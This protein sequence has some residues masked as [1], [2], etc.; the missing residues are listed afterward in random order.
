M[1][2]IR[3]FR[4]RVLILNLELAAREAIAETKGPLLDL[5]REQLMEGKRRDGKDVTPSYFEDP[6][7]ESVEEAVGY[8]DW[9]DEITPNSIRKRGT[10]NLF[11]IGKFHYSIDIKLSPFKIEFLSSSPIA[12]DIR[13]KYGPLIYSLNTEKKIKYLQSWLRPQFIKNIRFKLRI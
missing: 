4:N 11:I 10:P 12:K 9:K 3:E 13:K 5:N 6:Y 2:T 1:A 8:S 7:F